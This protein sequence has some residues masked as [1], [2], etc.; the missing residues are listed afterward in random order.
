MKV[1]VNNQET[2]VASEA[3][4]AQLLQQ[5]QILSPAVAVEVNLEVVPKEQHA[6]LVLQDGDRLEIVTLV[7]G[8]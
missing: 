3:T 7:G 5:L 2:D 8:G 4:V 1:F 6:S